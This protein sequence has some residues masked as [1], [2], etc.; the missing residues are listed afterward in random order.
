M[1]FVLGRTEAK[2]RVEDEWQDDQADR[3]TKSAT[4]GLGGFVS[5]NNTHDDVHKWDQKQDNPPYWLTNDFQQHDDVVNGN[6]GG[7]AR[8]AGFG[9]HL[10]DANNREDDGG[11][12][13]EEK[14]KAS[15]NGGTGGGTGGGFIVSGTLGEDEFK[16]GMGRGCLM[17]PYP[18]W[19]C[20][21]ESKP[22]F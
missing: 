7:P 3:R 15:H 4:E 2:H 6:D 20:L 19:E 11:E 9:E 18:V 8:F 13:D 17:N 5:Y 22:E 16:H 10:P 1:G 14:D 21:T 12:I